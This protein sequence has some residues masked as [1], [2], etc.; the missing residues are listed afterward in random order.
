M[1][2]LLVYFREKYEFKTWE[3]CSLGTAGF[4]IALIV[5]LAVFVQPGNYDADK[6]IDADEQTALILEEETALADEPD[7][8]GAYSIIAD[9]A[10]I[11]GLASYEDAEAVLAGIMDR[12]KTKGSEVLDF[13]FKEDVSIE[14]K[15]ADSFAQLFSV[16]DAINYV[17]TGTTEPRTYIIQGGDN[18]WDIA[19][20]NGISPYDIQDMNPLVDPKRLQIG[21]EIYLY[22]NHPFITVSFN[23]RITKEERIAYDVVYED[24]GGMYK[25]QTKV[26]LPGSYGSREVV[27]EIT[28][29]N[30][31]ITA[32]AV[33]S[34]TVLSEPVTQVTLRG[35]QALPVYAGS[36]SGSLSSPV[37][38]IEVCSAYGSRGGGRHYGVDLKDAKGTPIYAAAEGVVT[39]ASY[40]G[41]YGNIVK[42]SHGSGLETYYAH[43][44]TMIVSVGETVAQGQQ[45]ATMGITGNATTNHVHFEVRVNGTPQNPMNYI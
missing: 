12:Y 18:L 26:K 40:S 31:F 9:G 34:E 32:T 33:I 25:G 15:S 22:E 5:T 36:G 4:C 24:D 1:N 7:V 11:V 19:M 28:K 27:S 21:Q 44:D 23:E 41:S 13:R 37:A 16:N 6:S 45:I 20:S 39:Y 2:K 43:C 30:G 14:E 35:T 10:E 42:L 17:I 38:R 8:E 3:S 29:E